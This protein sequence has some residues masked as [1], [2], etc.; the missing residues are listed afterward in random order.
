[1]TAFADLCEVTPPSLQYHRVYGIGGRNTCGTYS[2]FMQM[3]LFCL[4]E[5]WKVDLQ[6]REP[7]QA[8]VR[9]QELQLLTV[10]F[11]LQKHGLSSFMFLSSLFLIHFS[12]LTSKIGFEELVFTSK[13]YPCWVLLSFWRNQHLECRMTLIWNRQQLLLVNCRN[14]CLLLS[15]GYFK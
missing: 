7:C 8:Q 15:R 4:K 2:I 13:Q 3:A 12:S 9:S 10:S 1:M 6:T 5:R 14:S 11:T